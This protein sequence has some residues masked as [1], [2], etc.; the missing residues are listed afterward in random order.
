MKTTATFPL[1]VAF[2]A[3]FSATMS[4]RAAAAP[5]ETEIPRV[6][7]ELV[8]L[9]QQDGVIRMAVVLKND[10]DQDA[11]GNMFRFSE[12]T[13]V[14]AKSKKKTF[15]I[16]DA[17]GKYLGGP[18][19]DWGDGGR[20]GVHVPAKSQ[21]TVWALFEAMAPHSKVSVQ[22][23]FMFPFDDVT[24][25]D[26]PG[27]LLSSSAAVSETKGLRA[28]LVSATRANQQLTVR[29]KITSGNVGTNSAREIYYEDVYFFDPKGKRKYSLLKDTEG[30][31]QARPISDGGHGGRYFPSAIPAAGAALMSLTF[32]APPDDVTTG[33]LVIVGF[34]P[35]ERVAIKGQGGATQSGVAAA[36]KSLG[37]KGALKE[38]KAEVNSQEIRI[39]LSA[40]VL[41]DFDKSDLK[42][43]AEHGLQN[44]LTVVKE[45]RGTKV[46][47]VGHTDV[48]GNAAYNQSLSERR[49]NAVKRWLVAQGTDV[50]R[51]TASGAGKSR[52]IRLGHTEADHRANRRVEIRITN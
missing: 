13:L 28:A 46:L 19:N 7:A 24:V 47:I 50:G 35:I 25:T 26:G 1:F 5:T 37:L 43:A 8:E 23:P 52:P 51:I 34:L 6:S 30:R 12:I 4:G 21:V 45:K 15:V 17:N 49:A 41:F 48:R 14:D 33:D 36:G 16:K 27:T 22:V 32:D 3:T 9:R 39:N 29:L 18:T 40:D 2:L 42:P 31:Y 44:L 20:W 11:N 38:L 10:S